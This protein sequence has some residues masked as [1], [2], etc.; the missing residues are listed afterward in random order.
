MLRRSP[1][2]PPAPGAAGSHPLWLAV[3]ASLFLASLGNLPLWREAW[4]IGLLDG[5][6][7]WLVGLGGLALMPLLIALVVA[8]FAW[9]WTLKPL[10]LLLLAAAAVGSHYMFA[11]GIVIDPTMITN[12]LQ[13]DLRETR[14]LIDAR[15]IAALL[16][17][18][19]L[20]ALVIWRWPLRRLGAGRALLHNLGFIVIGALLAAAL[21]L[22]LFQ[23]L[24]SAMRNHKQM[25]YLFNPL[26]TLYGLGWVAA[27]P[28]RRQGGP[29]QPIGLD[30]TLA[31]GRSGGTHPPLLLLVVGETA[32]SANFGIYGYPRDTTPQLATLRA[33]FFKQATSCG[34]STAASLP[35]MFSH[36]GRDGYDSRKADYENLLDLLQRAGLAVLWIDNQSGCKSLC[37]RVPHVDI[38]VNADP[39]LCSGGEC[40]DEILLRGLDARIAALP[41]ER[42]ARGIVVVLH[43]MGS[44]G[45]AYAKRSPQAIKRFAPECTSAALQ[46]CS[47]E[48][49]VNAYDN[50]ILY[51]DHV[52][53][54][55]IRWLEQRAAA[56]AAAA[57]PQTAAKGPANASGVNDGALIYVSDHGES[58]GENNL[59][60]HGLPYAIAPDVQK[61]VPWVGWF[62]PGF[63]Q[64]S[65]IGN[66]CAAG[67]SATPVS[68]DNLFHTV[69]GLMGVQTALYQRALDVYAP[70]AAR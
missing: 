4:R 38:P 52:L 39:A 53:A 48:S 35:C 61:Q 49:V 37:A 55:A 43:Q 7:G 11:Y 18:A 24:S 66:Q 33:P 63:E 14:D 41:A 6:R 13:T 29:L 5:P 67:L 19:V 15:F 34:T 26:N 45:P 36:L 68:H 31:P 20:P 27:A 16:A 54:A 58:L 70:C 10:L 59:Y 17:L 46:E 32:R 3:V 22:A 9:R 2:M 64:R 57:D 28:L 42:R 40:L 69:L 12:A 8:L 65:G 23:P 21:L 60:L 62:T 44:H 47:R 51:T 56:P 30:A 1:H 50:T 25:R